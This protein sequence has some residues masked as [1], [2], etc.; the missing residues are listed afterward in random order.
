MHFLSSLKDILN[1]FQ[2]SN[3]PKIVYMC[4]FEPSRAEE[5]TEREPLTLCAFSLIAFLFSEKGSAFWS[6]ITAFQKK[7]AA[8]TLPLKE[9][10]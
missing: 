2:T 6:V 4:M 7:S 3:Q 8:P 5:G 9:M 1:F 10:V